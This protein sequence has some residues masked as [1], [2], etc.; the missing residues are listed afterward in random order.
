MP[1]SDFSRVLE[2]LPNELPILGRDLTVCEEARSYAMAIS[3]FLQG[4]VEQLTAIHESCKTRLDQ[5]E[6]GLAVLE[7]VSLRLKVR[8]NELIDEDL[9]ESAVVLARPWAFAEWCFVSAMAW[10]RLGRD[11]LAAASFSKAASLFKNL[12]CRRRTLRSM[13]NVVAA[14]SR[15]RPHK[16]F[17]ADCQAI[18]EE[19]RRSNDEPFAGMALLM[20]SREYQV[21]GL[22]RSALEMAD[23]ALK[24]LLPERGSIQ[25][26]GA[27]LHRAHVLIDLGQVT[28]AQLD[29][30]EAALCP[31]DQIQAA[32][33]LLSYSIGQQDHIDPNIAERLLPT[34]RD[35]LDSLKASRDQRGNL[36]EA[37]LGDLEAQVLKLLWTGPIDKWDLVSRVYPNEQNSELAENRLKNLLARIRKKKPGVIACIN[38]RYE[39]RKQMHLERHHVAQASV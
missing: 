5:S 17:V 31:F 20:M 22:H 30:T 21:I 37:K 4:D 33:E 28:E 25:Y 10:E 11:D 9:D 15:V 36:S 34:W 35:R 38:G 2:A 3:A 39:L 18:V 6:D 8:R 19:A 32:R 13:Y 23:E 24:A 26:F 16:N 27:K 1:E 12:H 29:I 14:E 7:L